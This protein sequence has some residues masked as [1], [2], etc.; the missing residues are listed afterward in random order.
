[1]I[2]TANLAKPGG[3]STPNIDYV[4]DANSNTVTV[5]RIARPGLD[6]AQVLF[7]GAGTLTKSAGVTPQFKYQQAYN[8]VKIDIQSD[9]SLVLNNIS[10]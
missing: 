7:A 10:G 6:V 1:V 3:S 9:A 5:N 8:Q 2:P 4:F